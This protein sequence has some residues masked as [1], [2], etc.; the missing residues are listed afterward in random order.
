MS[1]D[2]HAR[3]AAKQAVEREAQMLRDMFKVVFPDLK[4]FNGAVKVRG[5][6]RMLRSLSG[7][8]FVR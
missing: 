2:V 7:W 5:H 1:Q 6:Q 8:S 3:Q 4:V